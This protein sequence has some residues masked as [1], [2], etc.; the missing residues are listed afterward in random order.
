MFES[1]NYT[2]ENTGAGLDF[3]VDLKHNY[4]CAAR[5]FFISARF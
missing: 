3:R 1:K 2:H 4:F 5:R